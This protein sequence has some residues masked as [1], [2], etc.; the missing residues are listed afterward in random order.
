MVEKFIVGKAIDSFIIGA[1]FFLVC[2]ILRPPYV[3]L[4]TLIVAI[5]NMIPYF[6]PLVGIVLSTLIILLASP[7]QAIWML[8]ITFTLQQFDGM[9]LGPKILGDSTGLPP[10]LVILAILVGGAVAGV[11]GMFF[12]VPITALARNLISEHVNQKYAFQMDPEAG[13][14]A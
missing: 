12:G 4:L 3:L 6:G 5:T 10:M 2:L 14:D 1:L 7:S 11:P 8:V 13:K 9:Y